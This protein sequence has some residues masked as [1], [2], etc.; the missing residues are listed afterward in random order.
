MASVNPLLWAVTP[1]LAFHLDVEGWNVLG[2]Q[3]LDGYR[4]A[5]L[6]A[7]SK[8]LARIAATLRILA[9]VLL[10]A[11]VDVRRAEQRYASYAGGDG[12]PG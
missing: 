5:D 1:R 7:G 8:D 4:H 3:F 2:F 9:L 6:S 11:S 10:P 12:S